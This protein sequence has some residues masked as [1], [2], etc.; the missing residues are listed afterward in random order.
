MLV[1]KILSNGD[2]KFYEYN[3]KRYYK[4]YKN[5]TGYLTCDCCGST[6]LSFYLDKHKQTKRC[7]NHKEKNI[8]NL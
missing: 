3:D 6:V 8:K 2:I 5:K 4:N 7:Q 1:K